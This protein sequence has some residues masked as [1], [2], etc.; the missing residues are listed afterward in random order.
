[1]AAPILEIR[2]SGV[3]VA[4]VATTIAVNQDGSINV[5]DVTPA[6]EDAWQPGTVSTAIG[7]AATDILPDESGDRTSLTLGNP[8]TNTQSAWVAWEKAANH[9]AVVGQCREIPPG[10]TITVPYSG[11][12]NAVVAAG[13]LTLTIDSF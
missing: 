7:V 12:V 9:P 2:V 8:S 13:T 5:T 11:P 4:G 10:K 1:M 6:Y 3:D